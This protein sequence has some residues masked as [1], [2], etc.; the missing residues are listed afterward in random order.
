MRQQGVKVHTFMHTYY[1]LGCFKLA[2]T[3]EL[4]SRKQHLVALA[5]RGR[6]YIVL[7]SL[8][9]TALPNA[10]TFNLFMAPT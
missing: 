1:D 3:L 10:L 2:Q 7:S 4:P 6:Y 9:L 5:N 8:P